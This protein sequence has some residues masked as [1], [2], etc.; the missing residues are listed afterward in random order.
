MRTVR[1]FDD[2]L[3]RLETTALILLLSVMVLLSFGQVVLRNLLGTG[4]LWGDILL[5]QLVLW[6]GFLG[7]SLA[8]RERK[9]IA[10]DFLPHFF[11]ATWKKIN[12]IA[13]DLVTA[14]ISAFLAK[15]AWDFIL[16]EKEGGSTLFLDIPVWLFQTILPFSFALIA[17]RLILRVVTE[18]ISYRT[19]A[20]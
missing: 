18:L 7:A 3:A 2:L 13:V 12:R 10:I 17:L 14:V 1:Q 4:I 19:P 15:A 16:F 6:V 5:R 8:V 11:N 9:H 20:E